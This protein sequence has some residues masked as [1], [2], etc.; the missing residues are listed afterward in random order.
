MARLTDR[1]AA[2]SIGDGAGAG[3]TSAPSPLPRRSR[4]SHSGVRDEPLM[5]TERAPR[6]W[7]DRWAVNPR[8]DGSSPRWGPTNDNVEEMLEQV[9][10]GSA[11]CFAPSSMAQYYTRPNLSWVP[12]TDAEPLRTVL[13]WVDGAD[14][15]L[16][17]GFAEVV[18]EL[19]SD[20]RALSDE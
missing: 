3:R 17:R 20:A 1:R 6:E 19:V 15:A 16:V 18:R 4:G 11:I 8:P 14:N 13:A 5:W 12:L 10:E 2:P 9:A 7:V